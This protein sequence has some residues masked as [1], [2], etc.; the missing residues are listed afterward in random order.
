MPVSRLLQSAR[1]IPGLYSLLALLFA[2]RVVVHGASM[3]P[4]LRPGERVFFD[5]FAYRLAE[6]QPGEVVLARHPTRP[7]VRFIK[8][9]AEPPVDGGFWL[10][11]DNPEG[12]TDSRELGVFRREDI[13]ARAWLVYWPPERLRRLKRR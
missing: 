4:T 12:S 3:Y 7:G 10:L 2:R 8:R 1:K 13:L 6:P 11:G 9:V 5:R